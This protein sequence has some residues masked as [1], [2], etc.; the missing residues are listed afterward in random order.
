M[1]SRKSSDSRCFVD[2]IVLNLFSNLANLLLAAQEHERSRE[3]QHG[4]GKRKIGVPPSLSDLV[5]PLQ[6]PG[7]AAALTVCSGQTSASAAALECRR[8]SLGGPQY[9]ELCLQ[10]SPRLERHFVPNSRGFDHSFTAGKWKIIEC[11]L[12]KNKSRHFRH[13]FVIHGLARYSKD[14]VIKELAKFKK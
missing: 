1:L 2:V 7:A 14:Y 5:S 6:P 8:E 10:L 9:C 12:C 11:I 3:R 4:R 13:Y